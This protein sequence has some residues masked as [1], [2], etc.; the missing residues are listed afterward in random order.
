MWNSNFKRCR[1]GKN[2]LI[3][4]NLIGTNKSGTAAI[5]NGKGILLYQVAGPNQIGGAAV[6][7]NI[8]S[9]NTLAGVELGQ[10]DSTTVIGNYIGT[11]ANGNA[12]LGNESGVLLTGSSK[13]NKIGDVDAGNLIAGNSIAEISLKGAPGPSNN[14]ILANRIGTQADGTSP[15][16]N[17]ADGI[18]FGDNAS[19]NQVGGDAPAAETSSLI[20]SAAWQR[21]VASGT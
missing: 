6:G 2:N 12:K 4:E 10:A 18:T 14:Q 9:G 3:V 11:N 21:L 20:T 8:I 16:V 13:N 19:Q 5:P 17:T 15:L 7:R 1:P